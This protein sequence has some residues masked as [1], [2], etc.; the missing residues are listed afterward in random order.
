MA[1]VLGSGSFDSV[2]NKLWKLYSTLD[3][4][5]TDNA[6]RDMYSIM[7]YV[8]T[9]V[10]SMIA[11]KPT[12]PFLRDRLVAYE[13]ALNDA[14]ESVIRSIRLKRF[15]RARESILQLINIIMALKKESEIYNVILSKTNVTR[16]GGS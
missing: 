16:P 4:L 15:Y 3:K 8:N 11:V 10:V 9:L 13:N 14:R 1:G 6:I 2:I 12:E 5:N 7:S